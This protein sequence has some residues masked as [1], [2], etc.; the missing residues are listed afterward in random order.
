MGDTIRVLKGTFLVTLDDN[1]KSKIQMLKV[2]AL[3]QPL[4]V[5]PS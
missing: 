3:E 5:L 2:A 4:T 1:V